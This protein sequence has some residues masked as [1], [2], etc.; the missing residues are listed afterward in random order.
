MKK[1]FLSSPYFI[2][3]GLIVLFSSFTTSLEKS[4]KNHTKHGDTTGGN[5]YG[6]VV[7]YGANNF[8]LVVA[9]KDIGVYDLKNAN[10]VCNELELN[11][12]SD[13]YLPDKW[14]LEL[15]YENST[16]IGGFHTS[17]V[18]KNSNANCDHTCYYWSSTKS[19]D[20]GGW[21]MFFREG[22]LMYS[23]MDVGNSVR[24]VRP[25]LK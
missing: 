1:L 22:L 19:G 13:W 18:D 23:G 7:I 24:P 16:A 10:K 15:M 9:T 6:G 3:L 11:G 21:R 20:Y 2:L 5:E 17:S 8:C 12:F 14:D 25:C 4:N